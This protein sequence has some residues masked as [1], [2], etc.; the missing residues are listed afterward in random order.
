MTSPA[1]HALTVLQIRDDESLSEYVTR[2]ELSAANHDRIAGDLQGLLQQRSSIEQRILDVQDILASAAACRERVAQLR[3]LFRGGPVQE[4]TAPALAPD[5]P[6]PEVQD[7]PAGSPQADLP[8]RD[9]LID[10][11]AAP[12][13]PAAADPVPAEEPAT[14]AEPAATP[15]PDQPAPP[16]EPAEPAPDVQG[17]AG[18]EA[19]PEAPTGKLPLKVRL[20]HWV[21]A[22]MQPGRPYERREIAAALDTIVAPLGR[23]LSD[24]VGQKWLMVSEAGGHYRWM[25]PVSLSTPGTLRTNVLGVFT[26]DPN[27]VW[28][29]EDQPEQVQLVLADLR[30]EGLI[31]LD[32]LPAEYSLAEPTAVPFL[33][34]LDT[35]RAHFQGEPDDVHTFDA[36]TAL[37]GLEGAPE[38]LVR[39]ALHHLV[40]LDEVEAAPADDTP[41]EDAQEWIYSHVLRH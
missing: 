5:A 21:Q 37:P 39:S 10:E 23:A 28:N 40:A 35:L 20:E 7:P 22:E 8:Q 1:Q 41:D 34:I 38:H 27:I 19:T 14:A 2:L 30:G 25:D 12:T 3:D 36:L 33:T 15:A 24:V 26:A 32:G 17:G 18:H 13:T 6:A 4:A 9:V 29:L 31:G 16:A 11:P